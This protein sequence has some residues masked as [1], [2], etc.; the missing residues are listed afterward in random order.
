MIDNLINIIIKFATI[1]K[2]NIGIIMNV[3]IP[4]VTDD[5]H[6]TLPLNTAQYTLNIIQYTLYITPAL[7]LT[8]TFFAHQLIFRRLTYFLL[9]SSHCI[10]LGKLIGMNICKT[11]PNLMVRL[12]HYLCTYK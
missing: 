6:I 4:I 2:N 3:N 9:E 12:S 10:C 7:L 11:Y 1:N 8:V 5:V